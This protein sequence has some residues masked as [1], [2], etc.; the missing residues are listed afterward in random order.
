MDVCVRQNRHAGVQ[1][2][3]PLE[4]AGP[5]KVAFAPPRSTA[6]GVI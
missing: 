4:I 3:S 1:V 2:Q 6:N 5:W